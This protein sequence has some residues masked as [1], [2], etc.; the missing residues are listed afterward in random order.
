MICRLRRLEGFEEISSGK[1]EE[2]ET[3]YM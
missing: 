2:V 1:E 3:I